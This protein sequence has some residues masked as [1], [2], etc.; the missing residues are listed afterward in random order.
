M[1]KATQRVALPMTVIKDSMPA[2][3]ADMVL[4]MQALPVSR[5]L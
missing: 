1:A 4:N 2:K 5:G 3:N